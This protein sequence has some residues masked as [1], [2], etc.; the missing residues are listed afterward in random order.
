M[1]KNLHIFQPTK[2]L[3]IKPTSRNKQEAHMFEKKSHIVTYGMLLG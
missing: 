3:Q 2:R 1:N